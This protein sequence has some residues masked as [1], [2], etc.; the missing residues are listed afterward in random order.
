MS[1]HMREGNSQK[2]FTLIEIIL[3]LALTAMLLSLLSTGMYGVM[4][5]WEDDTSAL[6][7]RLDETIAILQLERALQG[8]FPHSYRNTDTLG[9]YVYFQGEDDNLS[10]VSTVS[11]QRSG[12]LTAWQLESV[13]NEGVY[14]KLAPAMSDNPSARLEDAEL[15]LLLPN[16][17]AQFSYLYEELDFSKR[18]RDDWPGHELSV[19]PL[20]VHIRLTPL[21]AR[22]SSEGELDVVARIRANEHR[23]I[24]PA[25]IG[26]GATNPFAPSPQIGGQ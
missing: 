9:R 2:G 4:N 19:L 15:R 16:Y 18:W 5:D 3:S 8:A 6:D 13:N 10:W 22:N 23:Q 14:L 21:D 24:R 26:S 7:E 12:G 25:I 1:G 20:A 11:P 17:T